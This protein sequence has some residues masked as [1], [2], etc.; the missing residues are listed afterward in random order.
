MKKVL[1][2][3]LK[4][5]LVVTIFAGASFFVGS[6]M[7]ENVY[8]QDIVVTSASKINV[9][10]LP[11]T[12]SAVLGKLDAGVYLVR[13]EERA[14]G[15]SYIDYA[16]TPAYMKSEFLTYVMPGTVAAVAST[17]NA[18]GNAG[19]TSNASNNKV[20]QPAASSGNMVW[21]TSSGKKYHKHSSCSNMKNPSQMSESDARSR[22]YTACKKCYR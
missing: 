11:N 16:G 8:A 14:D 10:S 1:A 3:V 13:Y 17:Q 15:W 4:F 19:V 20:T 9:R 21:V 5:L 6:A 12:K 22:G 7:T 18:T 2:T